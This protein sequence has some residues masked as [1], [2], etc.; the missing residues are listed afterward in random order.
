MSP[1]YKKGKRS[2]AENYLPVSLTSQIS[3]VFEAVVQDAFPFFPS[4]MVYMP[5]LYSMP[6]T[7]CYYHPQ[8]PH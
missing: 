7:F 3:K 5:P 8:L 6:T 1:I 4:G 2:V